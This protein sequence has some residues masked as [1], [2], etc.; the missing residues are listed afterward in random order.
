MRTSTRPVEVATGVYRVMKGTGKS[1]VYLVRCGSSWVLI[2]A[3]W[4]H[5][6]A[7]IKSS[8]EILFGA[9]TLPAAILLT[10]LHPGHA[11]SA[12]ELAQAWSVPVYVHPDEL[13]P[14]GGNLAYAGPLGRVIEP[15]ARFP[16]AGEFGAA[17]RIAT[18]FDPSA[19]VPGLPDWQCIA[20]PGHTPGHASYFRPADRVL[21]TG[22]ALLTVSAMS[23]WGVIPGQ[24]QLCCPPRIST[25]DW[26]AATKSI[27][28]LAALEPQVLAP[29]HGT[30]MTGTATPAAVC[31]FS[32]RLAVGQEAAAGLLRPVDY[33]RRTRYR[34][35]P[36]MYARLQR[37]GPPMVA[38]GMAPH[39]VIVLEVP[40]RITGVIHRTT[41]VRA[42]CNDG[43]YLVALAG[44]SEWVRNV[45]AADGRVVIGPR[46][47][48]AARL[49]EVPPQQRAPVIRAYL[50]R[51]GRQPGSKAAASEARHYFGVAADPSLEEL[52]QIATYYPV[53]QIIDDTHQP[54]RNG[55]PPPSPDIAPARD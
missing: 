40:G 31:A 27:A 55:T 4:A 1:N 23:L 37:L 36:E 13:P 9:D 33:S 45:R 30:P 53:F 47:R 17:L 14:H 18:A 32:D 35:P 46:H 50:R 26:A 39:S 42:D 25:W 8:A 11:G 2:D 7:A 52:N 49:V 34:R 44:D 5:Q 43:H 54:T 15:F 22:D 16:P 21:I 24:H 28:Q 3:G 41:L 29:G 12:A 19:D 51:W 10:H 38:A 48:R 20:T 6:G